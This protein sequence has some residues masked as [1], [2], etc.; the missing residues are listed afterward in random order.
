MEYEDSRGGW[1]KLLLGAAAI[2]VIVYAVREVMG[3]RSG[4]AALPGG[5]AEG[6]DGAI[7]E[8]RNDDEEPTLGYDGMD[9]DTLVDWLQ[10]AN[11]DESTLLRIE[12]Y[13]RANEN[14]EPVL[15]AVGD[16]LGAFG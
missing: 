12:R 16:L 11:L 5:D 1:V 14:R 15:D 8:Y 13:E 4:V 7:G 6:D 9:R 10:D 3:R 2:G